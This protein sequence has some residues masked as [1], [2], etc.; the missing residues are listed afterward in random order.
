MDRISALA[1][2]SIGIGVVVLGLKYAAFLLT[3]SVALYSDALESTI[4]IATAVAALI[5]V[6]LSAVPPD[7][8]HPFGHHK[9]E[10]ISAVIEG[11]LIVVAAVAILH[12]AYRGFMAPKELA[13]PIAGLAVNAAASAI[14]AAWCLVLFRYGRRWRSP[15]LVA[16]ARHLWTDVVTSVGVL[17]G[18]GLVALTGWLLLDSVVAALVALNVIWSGWKL[19]RESI[20]GLMDEAV[21]AEVLSLVKRTISESAGSALEAHNVRTRRAG[22]ATFI[23]FHLVVPGA[24]TVSD[25]HAICDR[26]EDSLTKAVPDAVV[27]IHVEPEEKAKHPG[28]V[29]VI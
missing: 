14:N 23:D 22:R 6:R 3:G 20:G 9:A 21:P 27:S 19:I 12:A 10:Y 29:P 25:S 11:V 18:V 24:M 8:N 2:G 7:E 28:G 26:L 13:A 5:A 1:A 15:A 16:D 17:A 4:N